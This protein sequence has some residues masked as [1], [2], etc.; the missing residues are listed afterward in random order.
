VSILGYQGGKSVTTLKL[1]RAAESVPDEFASLHS[2]FMSLLSRLQVVVSVLDNGDVPNELAPAAYVLTDTAR[3]AE[4]LW[5]DAE[6]SE[7]R[8]IEHG[9]NS[10]EVQA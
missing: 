5:E 2:R 8:D 6:S 4:Q 9:R 3:D 10:K 1:T 7:L